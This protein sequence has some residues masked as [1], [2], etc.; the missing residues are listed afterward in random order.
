MFDSALL[1]FWVESA[2]SA[3]VHV[4]AHKKYTSSFGIKSNGLEKCIIFNKKRVGFV[5]TYRLIEHMSPWLIERLVAWLIE[6]MS[7]WLIERLV[8]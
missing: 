7:P 3:L 1:F 2:R 4:Y 6:H 5:Q 8:D